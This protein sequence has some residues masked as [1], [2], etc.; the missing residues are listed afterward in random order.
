M[1]GGNRYAM[2]GG[3]PVVNDRQLLLHFLV[4][5]LEEHACLQPITNPLY[6]IPHC[7][8]PSHITKQVA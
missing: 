7:S 8:A 1:R 5:E 2:V 4:H 6:L 3:A